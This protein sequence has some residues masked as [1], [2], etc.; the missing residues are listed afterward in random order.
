MTPRVSAIVLAGG[1][2]TR[3]GGDKLAHPVDGQ[4]LVWRA[5]EAVAQV[6]DEVLVVV[7]ADRSLTL[8]SAVDGARIRLVRDTLADAG[9]LAGVRDGAAAATGTHLLVVAGDMP[10]LQPDV[11]RLLLTALAGGEAD[12][13]VLGAD[14]VQP[15][16]TAP[17]RAAT[18]STATA[19]LARYRRSLVALLGELRTTTLPAQT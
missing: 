5:I 15:L 2:S 6:A 9:P 12:A 1:R 11:L 3:F 14:Q 16:P 19:L 8:P 13:A 18:T 10:S 7:A 4:P 17:T